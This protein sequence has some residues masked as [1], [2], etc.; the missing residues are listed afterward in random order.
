MDGKRRKLYAFS[1]ILGYSRMRYAEFTT[2]ISPRNVI[3]M[4]INAF[5][6]FGGYTDTILYDNTYKTLLGKSRRGMKI[7]SPE[8][9]LHSGV[10]PETALSHSLVILSL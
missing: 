5:R 10:P 4:H 7:F 9:R 8:N 1:M 6:Y 2:D 3:R